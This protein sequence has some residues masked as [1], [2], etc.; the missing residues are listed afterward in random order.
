MTVSGGSRR[1]ALTVLL[2]LALLVPVLMACGRKG[3]PEPS[4]GSTYPGHYPDP[5]YQ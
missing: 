4:E 3:P 2:I 5:T 1:R